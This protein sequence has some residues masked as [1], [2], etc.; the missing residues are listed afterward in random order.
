MIIRAGFSATD[1]RNGTEVGPDFIETIWSR[2]VPVIDT[3]VVP[4]F[5]GSCLS[6]FGLVSLGAAESSFG[7]SARM[8][9]KDESHLVEVESLRQRTICLRALIAS[10]SIPGTFLSAENDT[11]ASVGANVL[12]QVEHSGYSRR[13]WSRFTPVRASVNWG[14]GDKASLLS[15]A[16]RFC[17]ADTPRSST[18]LARECAASAI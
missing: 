3:C 10:A 16:G 18:V 13:A 6:I 15:A 2:P 9:A 8:G 1:R 12:R 11:V 7:T 4:G 17:L 14:A 5:T